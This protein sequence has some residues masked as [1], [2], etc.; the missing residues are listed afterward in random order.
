M[1]T[2]ASLLSYSESFETEAEKWNK[3]KVKG[4]NLKP[5]RWVEIIDLSFIFCSPEA[6]MVLA[7]V[8]TGMM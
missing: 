6:D 5:C 2:T 1:A 8:R 4:P 3:N 7:E